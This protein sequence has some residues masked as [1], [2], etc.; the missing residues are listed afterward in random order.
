MLASPAAV[1]LLALGQV[2]QCSPML[3]EASKPHE[4]AISEVQ[5]QSHHKRHHHSRHSRYA[6]MEAQNVA[7][8]D[9]DAALAT[10]AEKRIFQQGKEIKKNEAAFHKKLNRCATGDSYCHRRVIADEMKQQHLRGHPEAKKVED[11]SKKEVTDAAGEEIPVLFTGSTA[12]PIMK[13]G[14]DAEETPWQLAWKFF[15]GFLNPGISFGNGYEDQKTG[16]SR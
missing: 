8:T 6:Q 16:Q 12:A 10:D 2:V 1:L 11:P 9:A 5:V 13:E 7:M 4:H 14:E 3:N 15:S